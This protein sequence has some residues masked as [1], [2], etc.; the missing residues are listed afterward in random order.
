M[1]DN[2][3]SPI[4]LFLLFWIALHKATLRFSLEHQRIKSRFSSSIRI[5]KRAHPYIQELLRRVFDSDMTYLGQDTRK[6]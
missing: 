6:C 1:L 4:K 3:P 5:R 2:Q